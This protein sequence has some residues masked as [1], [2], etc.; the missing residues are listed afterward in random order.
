MKL[1]KYIEDRIFKM[2]WEIGMARVNNALYEGDVWQDLDWWDLDA[3]CWEYDG[4]HWLQPLNH[5]FNPSTYMECANSGYILKICD[6][7]WWR[8]F[9]DVTKICDYPFAPHWRQRH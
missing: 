7:Y 8:H 5:T 1:D 6:S 9:E 3:N 4:R 2:A